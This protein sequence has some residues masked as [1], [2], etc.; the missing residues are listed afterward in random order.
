VIRRLLMLDQLTRDELPEAM[1]MAEVKNLFLTA[2]HDLGSVVP[3]LR[4]DVS[5]T[6]DRY[7]APSAETEHLVTVTA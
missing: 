4:A 3:P 7:V 5:G 6:L 2:G 1:F